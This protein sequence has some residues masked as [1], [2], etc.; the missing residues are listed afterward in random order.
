MK[1]HQVF[2]AILIMFFVIRIQLNAQIP[3]IASLEIIPVNPTT[4]DTVK[5]I[6]KSIFPSGTCALTS[7]NVSINGSTINVNVAHTLGM[8]AVICYSTDTFTLGKLN[9]KTY[10]LIYNLAL[11]TPPATY[12]IDSIQFTIQQTTGIQ[13]TDKSLQGF[14]IFPNPITTHLN[15]LLKNQSSENYTFEIYSLLGQKMKTISE[16]KKTISVDMSEMKDGIYFLVIKDGM[17]VLW[18]NK[19][20]KSKGE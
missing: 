7:S 8:L 5:I 17:G 20:I 19:V 10:D 9:A 3:A 13:F 12:D 4:N 14:E 2:F 6:S 15:I 16:N 18:V 1:T 11:T